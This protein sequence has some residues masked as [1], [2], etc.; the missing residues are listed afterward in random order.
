MQIDET[1]L[2]MCRNLLNTK[3]LEAVGWE[4]NIA[5]DNFWV[6]TQ[7]DARPDLSGSILAV[8]LLL[9][10][11]S[12]LSFDMLED[13][14]G[15]L[16]TH[17]SLVHFCSSKCSKW[18]NWKDCLISRSMRPFLGCPKLSQI[19][20]LK[21]YAFFFSCIKGESQDF[22]DFCKPHIEKSPACELGTFHSNAAD[23]CQQILTLI[24]ERH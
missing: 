20:K 15:Q 17:R 11:E 21:N 8:S 22:A 7:P 14:Q 6:W 24:Q 9:P 23:M 10:V 2:G 12:F 19:L 1:F 3:K 4:L 18:W 5:S 16:T 13:L